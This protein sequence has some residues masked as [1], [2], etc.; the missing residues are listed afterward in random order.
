MQCETKNISYVGG[1]ALDVIEQAVIVCCFEIELIE[2]E[3][4]VLDLDSQ[5][6][7]LD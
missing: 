7:S 4:G 3:F 5:I 6:C 2:F 1:L